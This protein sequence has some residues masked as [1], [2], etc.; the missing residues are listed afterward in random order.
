M[1]NVL[2]MPLGEPRPPACREARRVAMTAAYEALDSLIAELHQL[3]AENRRLRW[4]RRVYSAPVSGGVSRARM[5]AAGRWF[6]AAD[7][8]IPD[9]DYPVEQYVGHGLCDRRTWC[10]P[11]PTG[12]K[13]PSIGRDAE[14]LTNPKIT[15]T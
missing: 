3:R 12:L 11:H 4:V 1:G 10:G 13:P 6:R 9:A 14:E 15:D 8:A 2:E 5:A 7:G